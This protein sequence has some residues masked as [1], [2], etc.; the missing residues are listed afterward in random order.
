M[1]ITRCDRCE[2]SVDNELSCMVQWEVIGRKLDLCDN[3]LG[4]FE[5]RWLNPPKEK[6][7]ETP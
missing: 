4:D 2:K 7:K 5:H 3:C 6:K 1:R